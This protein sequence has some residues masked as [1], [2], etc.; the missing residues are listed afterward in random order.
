MG[1]LALLKRRK[2][3]KPLKT[4]IT[5][6]FTLVVILLVIVIIIYIAIDSSIDRDYNLGESQ[7][8]VDTSYKIRFEKLVSAVESGNVTGIPTLD[9]AG[10]MYGTRIDITKGSGDFQNIK[11]NWQTNKKSL[12]WY[13]SLGGSGNP[14]NWSPSSYQYT[15]AYSKLLHQKETLY[16]RSG[17][18]KLFDRYALVALGEYWSNKL[19]LPRDTGSTYRV[20]LDN[21]RTFDII[22]FDT[23][24]SGDGGPSP[25]VN[26][27]NGKSLG[28]LYTDNVVIT[29]FD[30]LNLNNNYPVLNKQE[31]KN[32]TVR[33]EMKYEEMM[34]LKDDPS[35]I[36]IG[37]DVNIIEEFK[38][39]V[40][41]LQQIDD[42]KVR[43]LI[44]QADLEV[45]EYKKLRWNK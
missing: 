9:D 27:T 31:L 16:L 28:H 22:C 34:S 37:G 3:K 11:S 14:I 32:G 35:H 19:G 17:V 36:E 25:S 18:V 15:F 12:T 42:P 20:Y 30:L 23:A 5:E 7:T 4:Q 39:N 44:A 38:G 8:Q 1:A 41:A 10:V 2:E 43:E 6:F 33:Q 40:I 24:S 26:A 13:N 45:A 21:G 29:E